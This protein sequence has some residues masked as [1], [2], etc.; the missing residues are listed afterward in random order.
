MSRRFLLLAAVSALGFQPPAIP[1]VDPGCRFSVSREST[2]PQILGAESIGVP[3]RIL[4]QPDSPV[5]VIGADLR[6][7]TLT[8]GS[9]S[10]EQHG[11]GTSTIDIRNIS[12]R[13][14]TRV[15]VAVQT[16]TNGGGVGNIVTSRTPIEPGGTARLDLR[17]GQ[18]MGTAQDGAAE[19]VMLVESVETSGCHYKPSQP[20]PRRILS[21]K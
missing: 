12:D 18:G 15:D 2:P 20:W 6:R 1:E 4:P 3:I 7:M 17:M 10:F 13:P 21:G 16:R 8:V 19:L 9:S 14:L 5:A 11:T